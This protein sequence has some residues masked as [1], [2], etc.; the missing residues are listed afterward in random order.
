MIAATATA[1][2]NVIRIARRRRP[3]PAP[4]GLGT[5]FVVVWWGMDE[6][7][8]CTSDAPQPSVRL[9]PF[10]QQHDARTQART[11][12]LHDSIRICCCRHRDS[13]LGLC[14]ASTVSWARRYYFLGANWRYKSS[15]SSCVRGVLP[16]YTG[17][18]T[19][20]AEVVVFLLG[21]R[22]RLVVPPSLFF[23]SSFSSFLASCVFSVG[24]GARESC[25]HSFGNRNSPPP[26]PPPSFCR[27][28][29]QNTA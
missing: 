3:R 14:R 23:S 21:R 11:Q 27:C 12:D 5:L 6:W 18:T 22:K 20:A 16:Q 24:V 13:G 4:L 8:G 29:T 15:T 17:L 28:V 26:P 10:P 7:G 9:P 1:A 25:Q 19:A 2:A